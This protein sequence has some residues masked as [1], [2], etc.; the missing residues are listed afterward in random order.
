MTDDLDTPAKAPET[1]LRQAWT[2]PRLHA[3]AASEAELGAAGNVDAEGH[4]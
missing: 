3:L 2:T 4:S 1:A